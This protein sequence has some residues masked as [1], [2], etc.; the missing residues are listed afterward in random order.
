MKMRKIS[1]LLFIFV[2][3]GFV[4][5]VNA[6][7]YNIPITGYEDYDW[8]NDAL[9]ATNEARA[10]EGSPELIMDENLQEYAM[11]RA[12][13]LAVYF[14]HTRPDGTLALSA[15]ITPDPNAEN[16][17]VNVSNGTYGVNEGWMKSSGH[18]KNILN[19]N[20]KSIGIGA[21]AVD[22]GGGGTYYAVQVFSSESAVKVATKSGKNETTVAEVV[23]D[24]KYINDYRLSAPLPSLNTANSHY[25]V[26]IGD[27]FEFRKVYYTNSDS[28]S[29]L[30][31][32][33][34]L[35]YKSN[36]P[37]ILD[38]RNG[39]LT[40]LSEGEATFVTTLF[41]MTKTY[42]IDVGYLL[43]T[44]EIGTQ[45]M[46]VGETRPIEP[47]I[48]PSNATIYS[49]D[50]TSNS[51]TIAN[52]E[53]GKI[54]GVG[55]GTA[56]I[57][58]TGI[59]INKKFTTEFTV[60]V[61]NE[62]TQ[63]SSIH[64]EEGNKVLLIGKKLQFTATY[65]P[66][67]APKP[68]FT[69]ETLDSG[70]ATVDSD[71]LLT[72]VGNGKTKLIV[73]FGDLSDSVDIIVKEYLKGDIKKDDAVNVLDVKKVLSMTVGTELATDEDLTRGDMDENGKIEANDAVEIMRIYLNQA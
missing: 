8:A 26:G 3:F 66:I 23:A 51:P 29:S 11:Q 42:S 71:G 54:V 73:K 36:T 41:G 47:I 25:Y 62:P 13:E 40:G 12:R 65:L 43:D 7:T 24:S 56:K 72:A 9:K 15:K 14:D 17:I 55:E 20:Y 10:K 45:N 30:I 27:T 69:W 52:V 44:F 18:K 49:I 68:N 21:V 53:D 58:V 33:S 67:D 5:N 59:A 1:Y 22:N 34:S 46:K 70:V 50:Y 31:P 39:K 61:T 57:K 38:I 60:K 35:Q 63:V 6:A 48:T 32:A 19:Q 4:I 16:I 37:A 28:Y 64:I 2:V